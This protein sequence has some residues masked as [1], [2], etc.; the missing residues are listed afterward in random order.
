LSELQKRWEVS[1]S[2]PNATPD[3]FVIRTVTFLEVLARAWIAQLVD[4]GPPYVENAIP[5]AKNHLKFDF[6]LVRAIQGR[7]IT[8]GDIVAHSVPVNSFPQLIGHFGTLIGQPFVEHELGWRAQFAYPKNL[9]LSPTP[10]R[11]R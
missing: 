1:A 3:F 10:C 5:L 2:D 4:Y 7:T 8:L 6:E 11:S 9:F